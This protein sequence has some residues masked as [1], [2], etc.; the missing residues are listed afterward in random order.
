MSD[1]WVENRTPFLADTH[2]EPNADGQ[3]VVVVIISATF[4]GENPSA[5]L[6]PA[7]EQLPIAFSD[8][9]FGNPAASSTRYEADIAIV[10][11]AA[12]V[13]INGAA[14][15]PDGKAIR[16][17]QVG[18]RVGTLRKV[19]NV[20]GDRVQE[21]GGYSP[22]NP[23]VRMPIV[24]ERA[25]GG[26]T[27]DG[28]VEVRN[29]VGIG[30]RNARS[31]DPA[32]RSEAPNVTYPNE[33]FRAAT[34]RPAPAAFGA[35]GRGWQPRLKY[36]GTF[37]ANWVATQWPLPP[38]DYDPR[39]NLCTPSDQQLPVLRGGEAVTVIG[40]TPSRR[41]DFRLPALTMPVRFI[42]EDRSEDESL[43]IDT[44]MIEP[45]KLQVTLKARIARVTRR[46]APA[47]REVIVG[48]VTPGFLI[49]RQKGKRYFDSRG[50]NGTIT[51]RPAWQS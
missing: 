13:I 51:G 1:I 41:W 11:P 45:D 17:M 31:A 20:V 6:A 5:V 2:V 40:M 7:S 26:T 46:N 34:D 3:E 21:A 27:P 36:A 16:E 49:A 15:A 43:R 47:L 8:V 28:N 14:H 39:Y 22:P 29:P 4:Q 25:Y 38:K 23:F 10:K 37:D 30:Y 18:F 33:P 48:H 9:P 12:E 50:G 32:V 44:A 19:L 42:Y 35:L 24:Y